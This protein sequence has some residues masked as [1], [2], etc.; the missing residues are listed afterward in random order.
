MGQRVSQLKVVTLQLSVTASFATD[1]QSIVLIVRIAGRDCYV[2][3]DQVRM[4]SNFAAVAPRMPIFSSSLSE[5]Q[6][7]M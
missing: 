3:L 6:A 4:L 5:S 2:R 1:N 7:K